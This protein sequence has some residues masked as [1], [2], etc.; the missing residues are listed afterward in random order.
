M[1]EAQ[2]RTKIQRRPEEA[3]VIKERSMGKDGGE[4]EGRR[5]RDPEGMKWKGW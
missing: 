5:K 3:R 1:T 4:K 2:R